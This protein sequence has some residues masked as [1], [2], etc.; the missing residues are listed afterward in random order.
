VKLFNIVGEND[1]TFFNIDPISSRQNPELSSDVTM[2]AILERLPYLGL[3]ELRGK[4]C[5][6]IKCLTAE[7]LGTM[8]LVLVGCGSCMGGEKGSISRA[9][10]SDKFLASKLL[11]ISDQKKYLYLFI[12]V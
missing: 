11:R 2:A 8:F 10:V 4:P 1:L 12:S 9:S 7:L 3:D 6:V 5:E